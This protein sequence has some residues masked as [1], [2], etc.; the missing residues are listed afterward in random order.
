MHRSLGIQI[1]A[2][3]GALAASG[4]PAAAFGQAA[5]GA[6]SGGTPPAPV[7]ETS[8]RQDDAATFAFTWE[9]DIF[10]G[11]DRNYTNGLRAAYVWP[12]ADPWLVPRFL[13]NRVLGLS[14]DVNVYHSIA[15]GHSI[16]TPRDTQATEPLPDQHPY[17]GWAYAE[18]LTLFEDGARLD[19]V[20]AQ[21][22]V[23]GPAAGGEFVQNNWHDLIDADPVNGW[24]N[25]LRN[26]PGI[27]LIFERRYRALVETR[28]DS[29]GADITPTWGVTLGNVRTQAQLG[30]SFRFGQDLR[31]DFGPPR[32]RPALAGTSFFNPRNAFS[33][34]L[35][36]GV[37]GRAVA[38]N[39][40]LDGNTF[41]DGPS[42]DRRT[43]VADFQAGAVFQ[44]SDV[45][46]SWTWVRRTEEFVG[47]QGEQ[48][49]GAFTVAVRF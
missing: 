28:L 10:G 6:A 32:V 18:F 43:L 36:G 49:F 42:V 24:G 9:N 30:V 35:F 37:E 25:Q 11:T 15:L 34:Y 8:S 7:R 33:W 39:I 20:G 27:A 47:Q 29:F 40:F 38:R 21:I 16:F 26:E 48:Q 2:V 41:R 46:V 45:Q 14:E 19:T 17:A 31:R 3:A 5:D 22:G 4:L 1:C 12:E 23:V 13:A 44:F